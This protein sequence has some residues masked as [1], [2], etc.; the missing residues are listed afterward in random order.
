MVE[1]EEAAIGAFITLQEPSKPM[2]EVAAAAGFYEPELFP[3]KLYPK[4]QILTIEEILNGKQVEY[5]RV[6]PEVTFKKAQSKSKGGEFEQE[7]LL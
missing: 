6:A 7:R 2:K 5:P 1:G 4:I 3:G